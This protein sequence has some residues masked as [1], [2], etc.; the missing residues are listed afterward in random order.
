MNKFETLEDALNIP[1]KNRFNF[2]IVRK[3]KIEIFC[4]SLKKGFYGFI[5]NCF[6]K[7]RHDSQILG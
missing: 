6:R 1:Y 5:R 2:Y 4:D 7:E 3:S